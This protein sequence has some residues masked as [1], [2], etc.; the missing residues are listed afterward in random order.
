MEFC[1]IIIFIKVLRGGCIMIKKENSCLVISK[2]EKEPTEEI[3]KEVKSE[4]NNEIREVRLESDS[5]NQVVVYS[6]KH[7]KEFWEILRYRI[8]KKRGMW[9]EVHGPI[10][11]VHDTATS[12]H[13]EIAK[14]I[15]YAFERQDHV[16][17]EIWIGNRHINVLPN[18]NLNEDWLYA[19]FFGSL[20][21][22]TM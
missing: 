6:P 3:L 11:L 16:I 8:V 2:W 21:N 7:D 14:K 18:T 19:K 15:K 1:A 13:Q 9:I 17:K 12:T 4:L 22:I 10:M 5:S 20:H